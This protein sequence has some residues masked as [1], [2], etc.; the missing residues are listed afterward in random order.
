MNKDEKEQA[1]WTKVGEEALKDWMK[2]NPFGSETDPPVANE[3]ID[4]G[5][6]KKAVIAAYKGFR[7]GEV[8]VIVDQQ[9]K[10]RMIRRKKDG[11][12]GEY[13]VTS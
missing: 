12:W 4:I 2:E 11:R 13:G 9:K 5:N 7:P 3:R 8:F 6:G 1:A 10:E